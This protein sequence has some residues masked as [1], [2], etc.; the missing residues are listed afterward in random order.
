VRGTNGNLYGT[1]IFGGT[2]RYG[3]IFEITPSGQLTTLYNFT[4]TGGDTGASSLVQANNGSFYGTTLNLN[5][6]EGEIFELTNA[7]KFTI[8][9]NFCSFNCQTQL[10][11]PGAL[12]QASD[13]NLYG[14]AAT[15]GAN[16]NGGIF[17]MT[18][19]GSVS[20]YFS[21]PTCSYTCPSGSFPTGFVQG[22]DGNFYGV[23]DDGGLMP[24]FGLTSCGTVYKVTT[25]LP[26]FVAP[27]PNYGKIG[28][29]MR[30]IGNGLTGTTNVTFNGTQA[31][32]HVV[33]DTYITA[34]VPTGA[35]SG[36]IE[37]TTPTGT[38]KSNVAFRVPQ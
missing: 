12:I 38:L 16:L 22:T 28:S 3:T 33:S 11:D 13:G 10:S 25:G 27:Y 2:N 17:K 36:V 6:F 32:F 26:P 18:P 19:A 23:M 14:I 20:T 29:E 7:G 31:A 1:T 24:C 30:L 37:V 35:T 34:T 21:F 4:G 9:Y 15:G 5:N 8:L